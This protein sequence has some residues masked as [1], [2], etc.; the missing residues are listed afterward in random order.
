MC[1]DLHNIALEGS[2]VNDVFDRVTVKFLLC[3]ESDS[4]GE[5]FDKTQIEDYF[6]QTKPLTIV[7]FF[8]AAF[9]A[10][11]RRTLTELIGLFTM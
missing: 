1:F 3:L 5:C 10:T 4:H 8:D 2:N 7:Y 6:E 9:D 11:Q